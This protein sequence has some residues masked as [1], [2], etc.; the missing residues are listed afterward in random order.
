LGY[1]EKPGAGLKKPESPSA[2]RAAEPPAAGGAG[3]G[4]FEP[5]DP[6]D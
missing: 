1:P 3:F 4:L 6:S 2:A 5:L